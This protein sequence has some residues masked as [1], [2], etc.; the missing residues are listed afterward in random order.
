MWGFKPEDFPEDEVRIYRQNWPAFNLFADMQSQWRIGP[1]GACGLDYNALPVV[2]RMRR[3]P[4]KDQPE[5]F[6]CLRVM[7]SEAL[8]VIH[9]KE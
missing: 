5:L 7:E 3:I 8:A 2:F 6:D 1:Q 4:R 9:K